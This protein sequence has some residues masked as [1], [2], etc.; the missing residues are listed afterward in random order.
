V[1]VEILHDL[2]RVLM[3]VNIGCALLAGLAG[4][5]HQTLIVWDWMEEPGWRW[6]SSGNVFSSS[7]PEKFRSRRRQLTTLIIAFFATL[8]IQALLSWLYILTTTRSTAC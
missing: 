1:L 8:A 4:A 3:I 2:I 5:R 7:L 6:W